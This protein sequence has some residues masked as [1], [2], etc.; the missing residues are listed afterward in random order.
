MTLLADVARDCRYAA[1]SHGGEPVAVGEGFWLRRLNGDPA[2]V[3]RTIRLDGSPHVVVGVV[4]R[5]FRFP[6][7]EI[8]LF[9]R[10]RCAPT[11]RPQG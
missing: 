6:S 1:R 8:D 10:R 2:A 9:V 7:G 5:D 4:P 11:V 3:G